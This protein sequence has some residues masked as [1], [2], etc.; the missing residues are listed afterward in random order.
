MKGNFFLPL[1]GCE[2]D[3]FVEA[4]CRKEDCLQV[5]NMTH[6]EWEMKAKGTYIEWPG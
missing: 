5:K 4:I 6:I 1:L 3:S 2:K